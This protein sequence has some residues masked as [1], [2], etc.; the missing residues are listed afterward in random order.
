MKKF[1]VII[2]VITAIFMAGCGTQKI[3]EEP[4]LEEKENV[5][6]FDN[7]VHTFDDEYN[8]N[9]DYNTRINRQE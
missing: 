8:Q 9:F 3:K 2:L 6:T 1:I 5:Q 4:K 7:S